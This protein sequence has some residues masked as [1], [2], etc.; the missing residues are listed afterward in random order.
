MPGT[1]LTHRFCPTRR[2]FWVIWLLLLYPP[3]AGA[4]SITDGDHQKNPEVFY[5]GEYPVLGLTFGDIP[6]FLN[7]VG[8]YYWK[9]YGFKLNGFSA[10]GLESIQLDLSKKLTDTKNFS[11]NL[12]LVGGYINLGGAISTIVSLG[13]VSRG[14]GFCYGGAGMDINWGGFAVELD[15]VAITDQI[16][17]AFQIGYIQRF[18]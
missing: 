17:P 7:L 1:G 9:D 2:F 14:L 11:A 10:G 12:S 6:P 4:A 18:N 15:T 5:K 13:T 3:A 8:G 16:V